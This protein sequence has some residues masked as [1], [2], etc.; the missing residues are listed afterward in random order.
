MD[1]WMDMDTDGHRWTQMETDERTNERTNERTDGRTDGWTEHGWW[2][3]ERARLRTNRGM[4]EC[5]VVVGH[6]PFSPI[7]LLPHR[8]L[9]DYRWPP[10]VQST[11]FWQFV[12]T[13]R[14]VALT[15]SEPAPSS[16]SYQSQQLTENNLREKAAKKLHRGLCG[17]GCALKT[18]FDN[19]TRRHM[20]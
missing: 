13:A 5:I 3:R 4:T 20:M 12:T 2:K 14:M 8:F 9:C 7:S 11:T 15:A 19:L 1:D 6:L 18:A 10:I 17:A 16:Q